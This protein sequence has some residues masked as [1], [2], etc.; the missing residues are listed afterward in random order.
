MKRNLIWRGKGK[1]LE[2]LMKRKPPGCTY[3]QRME[4]THV[5]FLVYL[6]II[7]PYKATTELKSQ[8]AAPACCG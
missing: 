7:L 8:T 2:L 3:T 5:C 1:E 6:N 4:H